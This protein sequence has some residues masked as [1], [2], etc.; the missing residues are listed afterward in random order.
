MQHPIHEALGQERQDYCCF[1]V[2]SWV[3]LL[4]YLAAGSIAVKAWSLE[5]SLPRSS[6]WQHGDMEVYVGTYGELVEDE[7]Y[8]LAT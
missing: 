8:V 2:G 4:R 5:E 1:Q 3:E 6:L 7:E